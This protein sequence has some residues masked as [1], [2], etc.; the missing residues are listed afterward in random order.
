MLNLKILLVVVGLVS[1]ANLL[2]SKYDDT[3]DDS[4]STSN[5]GIDGDRYVNSGLTQS[6]GQNGV[7]SYSANGGNN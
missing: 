3:I 1:T 7:K 5:F 4:Y 6:Q 2:H